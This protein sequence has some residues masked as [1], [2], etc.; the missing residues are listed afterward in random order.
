MAKRVRISDDA[1]SNWYTLPGASA[2]L[3]HDAGDITDTIFGYDY[4]SSEVGLIGWQITADALYKGFAGYVADIK[5]V[6]TA[7]AMTGESTSVVSGLIYQIDSVSKQIWDRSQALTVKDAATPVS[8]ANIEYIDYLFGIVKFVSGYTVNG[9]ITID[10]FYFPT[11]SIGKAN[12]FT[13][14]QTAEAVENT[15][16]DLAQ[17]NGGH[18][19]FQ[20]GLKTVSLELTGIYAASNGF[21]DDLVDREEVI[22]EINPDGNGYSVARGFFKYTAQSQQGDVGALE[23][24]RVTLMLQVPDDVP[25]VY[26]PFQWVHDPLTTLN[27]S[28]QAALTAWQAGS[29]L[30]AQYLYDGTNGIEGTVIV[31]E[32]SLSSGLEEMN[33]FAVTLQG[34]G[35]HVPEPI[36]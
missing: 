23:E 16:Y 13:L 25:A 11:A 14:T 22:V 31:T 3:T 15:T 10:G 9:S 34:S 29:E 32:V 35:A 12:G 20:A 21:I 28:V 6:G 27:Y 17:A 2:Q 36:S 33:K 4:K 24:E 7:T 19:T 1:G 18:R 30:L 8:A 5:A 26:A